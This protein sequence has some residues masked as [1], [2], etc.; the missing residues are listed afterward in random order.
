VWDVVPASADTAVGQLVA[1]LTVADSAG[2]TVSADASTVVRLARDLRETDRR[3]ELIE[4]REVSRHLLV[5]FE[6]DRSE[7]GAL[8]EREIATIAA[9]IRPGA[10]VDVI[11]TSDRI[12]EPRHNAELARRRA[13]AVADALRRALAERGIERV[14]FTTRGRADDSVRFPNDR[15]DGRFLS[16]GV[17][18]VVE[19]AR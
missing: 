15:P 1:R 16:R 7:P 17:E 9:S 11:G 8:N 13:E 12:G 6:F 2:G 10:K 3:V 4:D 14:T 5:A 19:Q 18:I